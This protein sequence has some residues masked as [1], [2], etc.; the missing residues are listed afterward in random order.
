M[1]EK[2]VEGGEKGEERGQRVGL[3]E[4]LVRWPFVQERETEVEI[5]ERGGGERLDEDVDDDV[6][7]IEVRVELVAAK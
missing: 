4:I 3:I 7:I 5:G 2:V 1:L 6:W